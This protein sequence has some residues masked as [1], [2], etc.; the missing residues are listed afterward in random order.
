MTSFG[1]SS[2]KSTSRPRVYPGAEPVDAERAVSLVADPE[3]QRLITR[4]LT[5]TTEEEIT[6]ARRAQEAWLE[7]N[8]DDFGVLE[9]G[10]TLAYASDALFGGELPDRR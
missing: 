9:A 2:A 7:A 1:A 4:M 8:P 5:A 3:R 10:E 6:A